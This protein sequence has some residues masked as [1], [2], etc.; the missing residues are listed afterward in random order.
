VSKDFYSN[1]LTRTKIK[2]ST[3]LTVDN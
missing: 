3:L 1:R 2:Y